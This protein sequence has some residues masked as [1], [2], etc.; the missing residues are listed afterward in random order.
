MA[1]PISAIRITT[2]SRPVRFLPRYGPPSFPYTTPIIPL[3]ISFISRSCYRETIRTFRL[4]VCLLYVTSL[5][6]Q[7]SYPL[8][9]IK[10]PYA[11]FVKKLRP[12]QRI[13]LPYPLPRH[14]PRSASILMHEEKNPGMPAKLFTWMPL[15][16]GGSAIP[17]PPSM[18][19]LMM[20]PV[21]LLAPISANRKPWPAITNCW[22]N[23]SVTT[24][25]LPPF[26]RMGAPSFNTKKPAFVLLQTIHRLNLPMPA[27]P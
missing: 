27:K 12:G 3:L 11:H 21:P 10:K 17:S 20:L 8:R 18:L 5:K 13:P 16:I 7:T 25:F 26:I 1:K 23:Y 19:P 14:L 9:H 24:E 2:V 15:C 6:K 4:L 22:H